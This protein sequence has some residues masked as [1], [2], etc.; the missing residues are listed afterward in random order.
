MFNLMRRAAPH[1]NQ[2]LVSFVNELAPVPPELRSICSEVVL[3]R[4][5]GAHDHAPSDRPDMVEEFDS[6]AFH[7]ALLQAVRKWKPDIAQLEFTHMAQYAS[8]CAPAKT[9]L[10]EH[11]ITFDLYQQL[12]RYNPDWELR[13]Q[14]QRWTAFETAAW[15]QVDCV[16]AMS[17][18]DQRAIPG[19]VCLPNG[20]DLQ[21]F[22]PSRR[23]PDPG[24]LLF[25][26]SF[27]HLPNLMA[28]DFFLRE[29]WP[30][31]SPLGIKLHIIAGAQHTV[32][33]DRFRNYI[34]PRF[35]QPGIE[36]EGFVADVR[37]A[38]ERATVVIAPLLVSAGTNVKIM[39]A[40]AMGKAVVATPAGLNG[41]ELTSGRDVIIVQSETEMTEAIRHLLDNPAKRRDIEMQARKTAE[42]EFDWDTIAAAQLDLCER[43]L[44]LA[45][46][47]R[48][49]VR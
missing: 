16:V 6:P 10:V 37:P 9:V 28:I 35:D 25:V 31:L 39:E 8:D 26:G 20:V 11:D 13:R 1:F 5:V 18:K 30:H 14:L 46:G 41:L 24:R 27:A 4:R 15:K 22:R 42:Q 29:C 43:M 47:A 40:M 34:H 45:R 17:P 2:V 36:L 23:A 33:L 49:A 19:A 7:A 3:V 21:R 32:F 12:L 44:G 38:Y 48:Y